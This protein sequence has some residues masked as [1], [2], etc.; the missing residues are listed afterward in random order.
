ML[1]IGVARFLHRVEVDVDHVVEHAHRGLDRAG[2][3]GRIELA[4][5]D[6]VDQ[7]HR[8]QITHGDFVGIGI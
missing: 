2:K 4:V 3:L 7:I 8:A 5:D 1:H 6:V